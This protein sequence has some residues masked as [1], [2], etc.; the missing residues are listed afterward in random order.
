MKDWKLLV[1]SLLIIIA[2]FVWIIF[3]KQ[4]DNSK[5]EEIKNEKKY[6]NIDI[7]KSKI[8]IEN[9]YKNI[10]ISINWKPIEEV[11]LNLES[12]CN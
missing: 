4:L 6:I 2:F 11:N 10:F 1:S 7:K 9:Q 12:I 8:D 5:I 3:W